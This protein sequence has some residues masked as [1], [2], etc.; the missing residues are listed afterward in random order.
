MTACNRFVDV[1]DPPCTPPPPRRQGLCSRFVSWSKPPRCIPPDPGQKTRALGVTVSTAQQRGR[2]MRRFV[3]STS[4]VPPLSLKDWLSDMEEF[5][6]VIARSMRQLLLMPDCSHCGLVRRCGEPYVP[7][8]GVLLT[9]DLRWVQERKA[10]IEF[11][12]FF[13]LVVGSGQ[14]FN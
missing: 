9:L 7:A 2:A 6:A 13:F 5:D 10:T 3:W 12:F 14:E 4:G 1:S 8:P 11:L